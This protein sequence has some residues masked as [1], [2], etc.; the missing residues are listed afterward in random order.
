MFT[1]LEKAYCTGGEVEIGAERQRLTSFSLKSQQIGMKTTFPETRNISIAHT[2]WKCCSLSCARCLVILSRRCRRR[3]QN[4]FTFVRWK[5][6]LCCILISSKAA[7]AAV[8]NWSA[9]LGHW[10][11]SDITQFFMLSNSAECCFQSYLLAAETKE[12]IKVYNNVEIRLNLVKCACIR[13]G[14]IVVV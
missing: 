2:W 13:W 12:P 1:L 6:N 5:V 11:E 8:E 3:R 9:L 10:D 14:F 7:A 4:T